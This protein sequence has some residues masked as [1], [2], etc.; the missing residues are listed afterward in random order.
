MMACNKLCRRQFILDHS[1]YFKEGL[2][3]EDNLWSFKLAY[4]AS[5]MYVTRDICYIY[6]VRSGSITNS[7]NFKERIDA[8]LSIYEEL[9]N[10]ININQLDVTPELWNYLQ[11][12]FLRL[13]HQVITNNNNISLS[14]VYKSY[15]KHKLYRGGIR[16][17]G[18]RIRRYIR[19]FHLVL[20]VSM[21]ILY[22]R[23]LLW[24]SEKWDS[25][26]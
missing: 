22:M 15:R 23:F 26:N 6:K 20:P 21:S 25:R 2:I 13:V 14:S 9:V 5:S 7:S 11:T 17:N 3:Y 12:F 8:L 19:D 10:M 4:Y 24:A 18:R 16:L 1:L